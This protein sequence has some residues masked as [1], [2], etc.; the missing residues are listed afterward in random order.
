MDRFGSDKPDIR[1]GLE[2]CELTDIAKECDFKVF[3]TVAE[4]GGLVKGI[5]AKGGANK[6]SRKVIDDLTKFISVY[7]AKGLA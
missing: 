7:G 3:R 2:L 5:N 6:L 4:K 1:F